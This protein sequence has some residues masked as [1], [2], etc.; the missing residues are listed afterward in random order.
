[1]NNIWEQAAEFINGGNPATRKAAIAHSIPFWLK[2]DPTKAGD[3]IRQLIKTANAKEVLII[4]DKLEH[5][6]DHSPDCLYTSIE[7]KVH[8]I[9]DEVPRMIAGDEQTTI[10]L[11]NQINFYFPLFL[12]SHQFLDEAWE[13]AAKNHEQLSQAIRQATKDTDVMT[14]IRGA[15]RATLF[16]QP[17]SG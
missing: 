15:R 9:L 6:A 17:A 1:M 8:A 13:K 14:C 5:I 10:E 3:L 2:K 11:I 16:G 12:K 7:A 4:F